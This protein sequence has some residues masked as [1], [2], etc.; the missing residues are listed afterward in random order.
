MIILGNLL[1]A[2]C[3]MFFVSILFSAI[4]V[5]TLTLNTNA[6]YNV[7]FRWDLETYF[8]A[9][10]L[11][12]LTRILPMIPFLLILYI[13]GKV[14]VFK[15]KLS[16]GLIIFLLIVNYLFLG[17]IFFGG[18]FWQLHYFY[19]SDFNVLSWFKSE[20]RDWFF[21]IASLLGTIYFVWKSFYGHSQRTKIIKNI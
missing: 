4:I 1:K 21:S 15:I 3:L 13:I 12:I 10:A 18:N 14:F 6:G 16:C 20:Q 9:I 11:L 5:I 17:F 2:L 8:G 19:N 7:P